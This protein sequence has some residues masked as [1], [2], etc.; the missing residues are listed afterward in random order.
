M[1]VIDSG[2][3]YTHP[4]LA[5]NIWINQGE[6]PKGLRHVD[7]DGR[8]TF[9]DLNHGDNASFVTDFNGN[10]FI[11]AGDLLDDPRWV[12]T[13]DN[14]ANTKVDDLFGWDFVEEDRKPLDEHG[15]GTHVAGTIGAVGNNANLPA[16]DG[17]VVGVNW[18]VSLMA[19]RFLD[20]NNGGTTSDAIEAVNY[21]TM[22]R[23]R[24]DDDV[25]I[26]NNSWARWGTST[27]GCAMRSPPAERP[28]C[29]SWPRPA[30]ATCWAMALT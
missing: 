24:F 3:D 19:L 14:E 22:M 13:I 2:I 23:T 15:H 12:D 18:E 26:T 4:D 29:C 1:G 20:E 9:V 21:A 7:D 6:I 8:I 30:M 28:T 5:L 27:R 17:G 16:F 25:R 10:G 11:D